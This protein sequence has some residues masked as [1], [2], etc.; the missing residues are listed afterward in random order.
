MKKLYLLI[1]GILLI[2]SP[3][4][5]AEEKESVR[6][7][8]VGFGGTRPF[9]VSCPCEIQWQTPGGGFTAWLNSP[10]GHQLSLIGNTH[11]GTNGNSYWP[12]SGTYF[13][14]VQTSQKW[15]VRVI[16]IRP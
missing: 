3:N 7:S 10:D 9:T 13:L 6:F 5:Y 14:D 4:G 2:C 1:I 15:T 12:K 8:G 11:T 16:E